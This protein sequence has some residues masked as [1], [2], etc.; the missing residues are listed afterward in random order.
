MIEKAGHMARNIPVE[1]ALNVMNGYNSSGK[2][3]LC[4]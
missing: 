2:S 1:H 4:R 3:L